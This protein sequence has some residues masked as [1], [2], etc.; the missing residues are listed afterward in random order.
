MRNDQGRRD[1]VLT[2]QCN[3]AGYPDSK[4]RTTVDQ[5]LLWAARSR[6]GSQCMDRHCLWSGSLSDHCRNNM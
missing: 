5:E 3:N 2:L 1:E 6:S 4:S